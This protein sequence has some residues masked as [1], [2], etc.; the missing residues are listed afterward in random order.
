[1][2]QAQIARPPIDYCWRGHF[3]PRQESHL[4]DVKR[5]GVEGW[6]ISGK[7]KRWRGGGL[8]SNTKKGL[9]A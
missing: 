8:G 2:P 9:K 3:C 6:R 7:S 1:M 5:G 4:G